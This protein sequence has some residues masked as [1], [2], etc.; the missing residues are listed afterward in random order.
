MTELRKTIA[1]III[2]QWVISISAILLLIVLD[3]LSS[4]EGMDLLKSYSS[5]T[6]GFVGIIIGYLFTS[7]GE[8]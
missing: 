7:N 3:L 4:T 8:K 5:I 2:I 6:S 1:L